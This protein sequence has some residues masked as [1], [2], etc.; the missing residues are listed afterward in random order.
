MIRGDMWQLIYDE[1]LPYLQNSDHGINQRFCLLPLMYNDELDDYSVACLI[2]DEETV[3]HEDYNTLQSKATDMS[4]F[5][6]KPNQWGR[7]GG[8]TNESMQNGI[9]RE[10]K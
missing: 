4:A 2:V 1:L 8:L 7:L 5:G 6:R 3:L 9:W 10:F